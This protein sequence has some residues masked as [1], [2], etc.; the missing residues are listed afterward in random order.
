MP[1]MFFFLLIQNVYEMC[2]R[3]CIDAGEKFSFICFQSMSLMSLST[4][5]NKGLVK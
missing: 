3:F 2:V 1:L 4:E 5:L